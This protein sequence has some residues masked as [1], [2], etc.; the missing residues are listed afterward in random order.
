VLHGG[1]TAELGHRPRPTVTRRLEGPAGVAT[2]RHRGK[3]AARLLGV[4]GA[5]RQEIG[6]P[7]ATHLRAGHDRIVAETIAAL[8]AETFAL[9]HEA[10]RKLPYDLGVAEALDLAA[11][12]S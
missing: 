2:R 11:E 4:A 10:G 9:L 8:G 3:Q 5:R 6:V 7:V 12:L 1:H